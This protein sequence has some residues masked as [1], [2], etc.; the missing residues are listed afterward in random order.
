MEAGCVWGLIRFS[1]MIIA[2]ACFVFLPGYRIRMLFVSYELIGL[3]MS[4][5][6]FSP[7]KFVMYLYVILHYIY[8]TCNLCPDWLKYVL[9][10]NSP[11]QESKEKGKAIDS[12]H[13]KYS[14]IRE[15]PASHSIISNPE[16]KR[17]RYHQESK[18]NRTSKTVIA[19][20]PKR[21]GRI[22]RGETK[23]DMKA[24]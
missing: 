18:Q 9:I 21:G 22:V 24:S 6:P 13:Y 16:K 10:F 20:F 19:A 17:K 7:R 4:L 11:R 3:C 12:T 14:T 8:A 23:L 1:F 2:H 5:F 15:R